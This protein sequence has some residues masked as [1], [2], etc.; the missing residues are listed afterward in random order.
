MNP[1]NSFQV[2]RLPEIRFGSGTI[3]QLPEILSAYGRQVL[4][5][6]GRRSLQ[7]SPRWQKLLSGLQE[8]ALDWRHITVDD[9]PSPE[10]VDPVVQAQRNHPIDVV[11]EF[12]DLLR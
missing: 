8:A 2:A 9:E 7:D 6:T 4:L 11:A 5:V 10:L 1:F 12:A 3:D